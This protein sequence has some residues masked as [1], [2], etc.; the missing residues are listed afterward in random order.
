MPPKQRLKVY[1]AQKPVI[2]LCTFSASRAWR[3]VRVVHGDQMRG[4][5]KENGTQELCKSRGGR[6]GLSVP[7]SPYGL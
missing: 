4:E 7:N 2:D 5:T 3:V 6:S 1:A